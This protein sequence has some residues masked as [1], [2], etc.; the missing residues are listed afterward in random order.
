MRMPIYGTLTDGAPMNKLALH[1][2]RSGFLPP[3]RRAKLTPTDTPGLGV[4][5]DFE[6]LGAPVATYGES[7]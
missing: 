1:Q 2:P 7:P 3:A 4:V 6:S 5:P